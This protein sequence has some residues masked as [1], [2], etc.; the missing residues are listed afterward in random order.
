MM[1]ALA[2]PNFRDDRLGYPKFFRHYSLFSARCETAPECDDTIIGKL[3]AFFSSPEPVPPF[4][5]HV[6]NIFALGAEKK[7]VRIDTPRIIA[8]VADAAVGLG[9]AG[10]LETDPVS[11][12]VSPVAELEQSITPRVTRVNPRPALVRAADLNLR[13]K[14]RDI[15]G[16]HGAVIAQNGNS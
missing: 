16:R 4:S 11:K 15:I 13:P 6:S 1:P 2:C 5:D 3:R 8:A 9:T 14:T 7:M 12:P 10:N